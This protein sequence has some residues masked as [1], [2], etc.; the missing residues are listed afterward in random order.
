MEATPRFI[1]EIV[2]ADD[3]SALQKITA[4]PRRYFYS[5]NGSVIAP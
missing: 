2:E 5:K 3:D 1:I 4:Q